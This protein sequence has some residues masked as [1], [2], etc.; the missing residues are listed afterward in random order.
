MATNGQWGL[1]GV[2]Y[3]IKKDYRVQM[4]S[5]SQ[6]SFAGIRAVAIPSHQRPW[7]R[8]W[9]YQWHRCPQKCVCSK[10][11]VKVQA[12]SYLL[13]TKENTDILAIQ[14]PSDAPF[15]I[16][17]KHGR[18]HVDVENPLPEPYGHNQGEPTFERFFRS[19]FKLFFKYLLITKWYSQSNFTSNVFS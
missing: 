18:G 14:I 12:L 6:C 8:W 3:M 15:G 16:E 1:Y 9:H 5:R 10:M 19:D 4:N 11:R 13:R 2:H 7:V 17:C